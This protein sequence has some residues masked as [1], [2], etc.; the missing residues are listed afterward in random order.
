MVYGVLDIKNFLAD[1]DETQPK[2]FAI[3][4]LTI[5]KYDADQKIE[6]SWTASN[7]T[8]MYA[9]PSKAVPILFETDPSLITPAWVTKVLHERKVL[10]EDISVVSICNR[11]VGDVQGY[12]GRAALF[13]LTFS[14]EFNVCFNVS[15]CVFL[16]T[17]F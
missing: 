13:D 8:A 15:A 6:T 4:N 3:E 9:K 17:L 14:G 12:A 1:F 10:P 7:Q 2:R 16:L 11:S 5:Y